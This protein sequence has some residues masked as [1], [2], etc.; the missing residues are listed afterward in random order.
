MVVEREIVVEEQEII[1]AERFSRSEPRGF[2]GHSKLTNFWAFR[3]F[4]KH[5]QLS[6]IKF[7]GHF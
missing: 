1:V 4:Q 6:K 7:L 2:Y 3:H 5:E